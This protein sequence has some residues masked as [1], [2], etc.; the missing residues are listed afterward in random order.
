MNKQLSYAPAEIE[1]NF[2]CN[3]WAAV[4]ETKTLLNKQILLL[5]YA[6]SKSIEEIAQILEVAPEYIEDAV[7]HMAAVNVLKEENGNYYTTFPMF[8]KYEIKKA[9]LA[10]NKEILQNHIPEKLDK[11]IDSLKE[12]I[13]AVDFYGNDFNWKYLKWI[14]YKFADDELGNFMRKIYVQKTDEIII[15]KYSMT[16]QNYSYSLIGEYKYADDSMTEQLE[17]T[18]EAL[19][20]Y[21]WSYYD[22]SIQDYGWVQ[23]QFFDV[24]PFPSSWG[25][26]DGEYHP[27]CGRGDYIKTS[28]VSLIF[29][30]IEN[31]TKTLNENEEKAVAEMLTHG[32]LTELE[33][34]GKKA[35][36]P[37]IPVFPK[38][39]IQEIKTILE[40]AL[41]TYALEIAETILQTVGKTLL[42]SL[43]G[44]KERLAQFYVFWLI[45]YFGPVKEFFWYGINK[46]GFEIPNDYKKSAAAMYLL[47]E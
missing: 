14:M 5:C 15:D 36:K 11:L 23:R 10:C 26:D 34:D 28:D 17:T 2:C 33:I 41:K 3:A 4:N 43:H 25:H 42:P 13:T 18:K 6:E 32:V 46:G 40:K 47:K 37:A 39:A 45:F 20:H 21:T 31:P 7:T 24:P 44:R 22:F 19:I 8:S 29:Q 12:E 16:T 35:Y 38:K 27:E 9:K 30:L 1:I